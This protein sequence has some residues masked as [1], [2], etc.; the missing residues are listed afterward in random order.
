MLDRTNAQNRALVKANVELADGISPEV[1]VYHA[2]ER[3]MFGFNYAHG[4]GQAVI[5]YVEYSGGRR[6]S[7]I[8]DALAY[9]RLTGSLPAAAPSV[10]P[11][12]RNQYFRNDLSIGASYATETRVTFNLEYHYHEAGFTGA[13]WHNWF[14]RAHVSPFAPQGLWYFRGYAQDQQE[15]ISRHMAFARFDWVDAFVPKLE[16]T[17]LANVDLYD[18]STLYQLTADYYLSDNWTLGGLATANVGRPRSDF[19][20]LP[21]FGG[22]LVKLARY[23]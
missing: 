19:G 12:N 10:L 11:D 18:G 23:F 6:A 8:D 5:A 14:A 9:A 4:I 3:T 1:L 17:G 21:T 22:V 7:L 15:P 2:G 13:D 16:L 20:S